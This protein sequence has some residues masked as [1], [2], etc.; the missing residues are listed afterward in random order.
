VAGARG[1]GTIDVNGAELPVLL[2]NRAIAEAE[3]ATGKSIV[4]LAQE[5]KAGS[6][7]V[8]DIAALLR[9]GLEYGRRDAG[10]R[11][12]M[13][14]MADTY[15]V[16][17]ACGFAVAAQIVLTA[18]AEVLSYRPDADALPPAPARSSDT[19]SA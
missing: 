11:R 2:T 18:V 4:Q 12:Q 10:L 5:A 6:I 19:S 3:K 15:D 13:Y 8:G 9:A 17:D 1:E 16:M 14:T 7:G